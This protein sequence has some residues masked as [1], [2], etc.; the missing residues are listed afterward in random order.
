MMKKLALVAV[1]MAFAV[2]AFAHKQ[3]TPPPTTTNVTVNGTNDAQSFGI[4]NSGL[5]Y[6]SGSSSKN[7]KDNK[8]GSISTGAANAS[9]AVVTD[10][11]GVMVTGGK[12]N[13]SVGVGGS[14]DVLSVAG[15]N[16]GLNAVSGNGSVS[17]GAAG[18]HSFVGSSINT[19]VVN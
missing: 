2:P 16:S 4:A 6:V 19:V 12:S 15:S 8:G 3:N 18:A 13:V 11:N 1:A 17:T 9:S 10:V 7:K 14:N 5:N